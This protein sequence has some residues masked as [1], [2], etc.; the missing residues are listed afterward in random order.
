MMIELI[1]LRGDVFFMYLFHGSLSLFAGVW[2]R[3][4]VDWSNTQ[5][6]DTGRAAGCV[7][8][9]HVARSGKADLWR[10]WYNNDSTSSEQWD[11][12]HFDCVTSCQSYAVVNNAG[13]MYYYIVYKPYNP[14][15]LQVPILIHLA[16]N[17]V[18]KLTPN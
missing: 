4:I 8:V 15:T 12:S 7:W 17:A 3:V 6:S 10:C 5:G 9:V 13:C 16:L 18:K 11:I 1:Q 2:C 14:S